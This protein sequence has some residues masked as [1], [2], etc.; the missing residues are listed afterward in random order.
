MAD[1]KS[2]E[3]S[4]RKALRLHPKIVIYTRNDC[5]GRGMKRLLRLASRE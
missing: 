2:M 1:E 5:V 4:H 3:N